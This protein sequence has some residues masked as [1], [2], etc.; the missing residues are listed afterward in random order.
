MIN[1]N[2]IIS[3]LNKEGVELPD[4]E[5]LSLTETLDDQGFDSMIRA[6]VYITLGEFYKVDL[7]EVEEDKLKT[8]QSIIDFIENAKE[9]NKGGKNERT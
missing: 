7:M 2:N 5:S 8:F 9:K 6:D 4:V 3:I 1:L